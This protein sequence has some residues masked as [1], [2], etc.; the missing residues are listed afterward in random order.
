VDVAI[1]NEI[2]K[3]DMYSLLKEQGIQFDLDNQ[4]PQGN[5]CLEV[6][7]E[8]RHPNLLMHDSRFM[9]HV[10]SLANQQLQR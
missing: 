3:Y 10:Q 6:I 1:E 7:L 5:T 8:T 9:C 2:P 4:N